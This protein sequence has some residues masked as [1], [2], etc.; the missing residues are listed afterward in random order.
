MIQIRK[1]KKEILHLQKLLDVTAARTEKTEVD[2]EDVTT[3]VLELA[4]LYAEQDDAI[5]EL[6]EI[7][8]G[9]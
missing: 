5:V 4:E 9:E 1:G 7:I 3:A 6:A 2:I 8:G